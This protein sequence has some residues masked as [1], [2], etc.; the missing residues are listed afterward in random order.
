MTKREARKLG[1]ETGLEILTY[2]DFTREEKENADNFSEAYWEIAEN[3]KQYAGDTTEDFR[4]E[5]EWEG[6][7]D[8]L[9]LALSDYIKKNY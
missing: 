8:G 1:R 4:H 7:E 2:G 5:S 3:R 9:G 6:Y